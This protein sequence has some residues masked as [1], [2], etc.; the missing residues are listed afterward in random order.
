MSLKK[1]VFRFFRIPG[2]LGFFLA[3]IAARAALDSPQAI[4][5]TVIKISSLMGQLLMAVSVAVILYAGFKY[6]TAGGNE[7][8]VEE[9]TKVLTYAI[10]GII[11]GLLAF[12]IPEIVRN[13][14]Q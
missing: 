3:P 2:L 10:V 4:I 5:G 1:M 11:V 12:A 14:I 9:A 6:L 8:N 7:Q 13:L